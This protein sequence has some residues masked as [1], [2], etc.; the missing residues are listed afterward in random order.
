MVLAAV[1]VAAVVVAGRP[2]DARAFTGIAW[3]TQ[4]LGDRGTNVATIQSLLVQ[5][6]TPSE[7][8]TAAGRSVIVRTRPP[9][10]PPVDGIF[11]ASTLSAVKWYQLARGLAATG[12]VDAATWD[13]LAVAVGPGST[14]EAVRAVQ[15]LLDEKRSAALPQ[16]GVYGASTAAAVRT[17]QSH[18]ALPVTGAMDLATWR[19]LVWHFELPRFRANGLCD[20]SSGNGPANWGTSSTIAFLETAAATEFA[21]GFGR[22]ALGDV[23][24]EHG[25]DIPGHETHEQGLDADI[26]PMRF[27]NDQCA[28]GTRWNLSSYDRTATRA[29]VNAIR[30]AGAG[31]VK[32]IFFNDPVLIREG[33]VTYNSGHDDHLHVRYCEATHLLPRYDC[34]SSV[35]T[36][37]I[38]G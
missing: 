22:V 24:F 9:A 16:D 11:G 36:T 23:G 26:R 15:R 7:T 27:A 25:G 35:G 6:L 33:L 20:F 38:S 5:R 13:R 31:H 3:P 2:V 12:I 30:A 14:G 1:A 19:H 17:F 4:S 32:V 10:P 28:V 37:P 29:L 34:R 21:G 8:Q 18:V